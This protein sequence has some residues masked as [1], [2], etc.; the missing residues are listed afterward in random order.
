MRELSTYPIDF[1]TIEKGSNVSPE[2]IEHAYGLRRTDPKYRLKQLDLRDR[3]V[4]E[5]AVRGLRVT[6]KLVGD[7]LRVL[8]DEEAAR[9]NPDMFDRSIRGA[10]R[11][12]QRNTHVD[13]SQL[14]EE[15]RARHERNLEV[16]GKMLQGVRSARRSAVLTPARRRTPGLKGSNDG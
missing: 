12:H 6:V 16:Q 3:I 11:A 7:S 10:A 8:T 13:P 2:A 15:Q 9:Y 1:D 5:L 14:T 4:D